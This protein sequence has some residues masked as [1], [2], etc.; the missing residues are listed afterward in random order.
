MNIKD[1]VEKTGYCPKRKASTHGGEYCSPCPFCKDGD[2]RF[3]VWPNKA[4]KNG[5]YQ[6]GRFTCRVCQKYGDAITFLREF[7]CL[8]YKNAC[9]RLS[10][11]PKQRSNI[12][13]VKREIK[14]LITDD[15]PE[16]WKEKGLA[17]VEWC[18][19]QLMSN[20]AMLSFLQKTRG[21]S[22]E[23][24]KCFKIGFCPKDY[25]RERKDWGLNEQLKEDGTPKKQWLPEGIVIPTFAN[26]QVIKIKIRRSNW[27]T[28]DRLPKY[29][30]VSGSKSCPSVYGDT[31]LNAALIIESELDALLVQQEVKDIVYCIALGGSTKPIDLFTDQLIKQT[32]IVLFCPDFDKA[33]AI[34]WMKWKNIYP[35]IHRVFTPEEKSVGDAFISE[36]NLREWIQPSLLSVKR[37]TEKALMFNS[38]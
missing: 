34:A 18:H 12:P 5:E 20:E 24:I 36:L 14:P 28:E 11:E 2:D 9:A 27:K 21:L 25:F 35:N 3:L 8:T 6:G 19:A 32:S 23:S 33:G 10:I 31:S 7:H 38:N 17:F 16:L 1:L 4:N 22:I 37:S 13:I 15:P 29:I 26:D 30:E